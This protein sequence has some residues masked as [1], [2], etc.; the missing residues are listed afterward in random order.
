[1][2]FYSNYYIEYENNGD[3]HKNL[4]IEE[5]LNKIKPYWQDTII[6]L[7]KS[8]TCKI[9]LTIPINFISFKDTDKER[10]MHSQ[11]DNI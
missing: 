8:E 3:G 1:M 7:Q 4:S 6:N 10:T 2:V 11:S 5:Y 9:Q